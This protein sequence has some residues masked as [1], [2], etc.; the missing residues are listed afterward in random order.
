MKR[1]DIDK[2]GKRIAD[3]LRQRIIDEGLISSGEL[4]DSVAYKISGEDI[5]IEGADYMI[6]VDKGSKPHSA[7]V[8]KLTPWAEMNGIN[9]WALWY[10][11]K[12]NGTKAHPFLDSFLES[13]D[14]DIWSVVDIYIDDTMNDIMK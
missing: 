5:L 3:D 12:E 7:P 14:E 10:S 8:D 11:I 2:I 6:A 1:L 13:I 4:Y 9:P